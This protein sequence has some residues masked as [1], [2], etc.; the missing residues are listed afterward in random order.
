MRYGQGL[1]LECGV[2]ATS[3]GMPVSTVRPQTL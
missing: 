1:V 2:S 3:L